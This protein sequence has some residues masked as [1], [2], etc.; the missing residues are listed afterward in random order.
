MCSI[1]AAPICPKLHRVARV[2][3]AQY[4]RASNILSPT[5][6]SSSF[7]ITS[8]SE[9]YLV[10]EWLPLADN[11][12]SC[13][14]FFFFAHFYFPASGQW[15]QVSSLLPPGSCLQ[16]YAHRVQQSHYCWS[17]FHR[18]L[19]THALA[20][21]ASEFERKKG[22]N[23]FIRVLVCSRGDSNSRKLPIRSMLKDNLICH[24]G[25]RLKKIILSPV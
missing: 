9:K 5:P 3:P 20:L 13:F 19:L 8:R 22:P 1:S 4:R 24:R 17:I 10:Q 11:K 12:H 25:D 6:H 2:T 18:V 23:E 16:F 21:S 7:V 14:F 15:S